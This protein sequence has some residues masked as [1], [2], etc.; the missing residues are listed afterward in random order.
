MLSCLNNCTH[1]EVCPSSIHMISKKQGCTLRLRYSLQD[2]SQWQSYQL[3]LN[4]FS[5]AKINAKVS[6]PNLA[7][8]KAYIYA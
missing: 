5:S 4:P 6:A 7:R 8:D 1:K 2:S 3:Q